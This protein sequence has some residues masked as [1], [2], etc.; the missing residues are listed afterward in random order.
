VCELSLD[1][2]QAHMTGEEEESRSLDGFYVR[3]LRVSYCSRLLDNVNLRY[4]VI[5]RNLSKGVK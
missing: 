4:Y 3:T 5:L 2:I 1:C